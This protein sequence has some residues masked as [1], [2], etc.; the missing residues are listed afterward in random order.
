MRRE[1]LARKSWFAG[2]LGIAVGGFGHHRGSAHGW[3]RQLGAGHHGR[4]VDQW[5][6]GLD[7]RHDVQW[8]YATN[9]GWG[10]LDGWHARSRWE[11]SW[12]GRCEHGRR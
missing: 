6:G 4:N 3:K 1:H 7:E 12:H 5:R 2:I 10:D 8:R 9:H 11:R